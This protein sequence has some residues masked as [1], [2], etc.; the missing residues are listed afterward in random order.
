MFLVG[1]RRAFVG[2]EGRGSWVGRG[3]EANA[4]VGCG[5]VHEGCRDGSAEAHLLFGGA[6]V[7]SLNVRE[8]FVR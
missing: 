4:K 1:D 3:G 8:L 7:F 5:G 6:E 2:A